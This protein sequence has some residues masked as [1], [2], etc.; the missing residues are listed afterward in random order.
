VPPNWD[1]GYPNLLEIEIISSFQHPYLVS[2]NNVQITEA[3]ISFEMSGAE[4]D[5]ESIPLYSRQ[6]VLTFFLQASRGLEALHKLQ[7]LHL[8][9]KPAN[10]LIYRQEDGT[11]IAKLSDFGYSHYLPFPRK[12]DPLGTPF[13]ACPEFLTNSSINLDY[14]ADIW[15]LAMTFLFFFVDDDEAYGEGYSVSEYATLVREFWFG[16]R[17]KDYL[18]RKIHDLRL[19]E[20]FAGTLTWAEQRW[21]LDRVIS[22]LESLVPEK[23][24]SADPIIRPQI[25]ISE[26]YWKPLAERIGMAEMPLKFWLSRLK[27]D[28]PLTEEAIAVLI[29][30]VINFTGRYYSLGK[31]I[32]KTGLSISEKT[33]LILER[34]ILRCLYTGQ[35]EKARADGEQDPLV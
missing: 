24:A 22:T 12:R 17:G 30:I 28:I 27:P 18:Q 13:Y 4:G 25:I 19:R 32:T 5:L 29:Y 2:G 14:K 11:R 6:E 16:S 8:D 35:P 10:I 26:P 33:F 9:L 31:Y 15:S 34:G 21:T 20:L 3:G 23:V 1:K 7:I